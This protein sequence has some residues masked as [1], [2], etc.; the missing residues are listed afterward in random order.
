MITL[1]RG[2]EAIELAP[3]VWD[4]LQVFAK[5]AG[6]RPAGVVDTEDRRTHRLYGPGRIVAPRDARSFATA[7]ER[8]VN[9]EQGDSGELDLAA[10]VALVNFLRGGA[11]AIR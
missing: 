2:A 10:I 8:V 1:V 6:W 4:A 11:F 9:G 5:Q 7:L 3:L